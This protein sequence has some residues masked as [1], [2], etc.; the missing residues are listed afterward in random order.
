MPATQNLKQDPQ[1]W[2]EH[3]AQWLDTGLSQAAYCRQHELC[4]NGFS[5]YKRKYSTGLVP[6][7]HK[8]AGFVSVQILPEPQ[9]HDPLSLHF[10]NGVRLI[11]ITAS[12]VSVVKQLAEML[13]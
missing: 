2:R 7:K 5:Y 9:H 4:P 10:T 1:L 6:V 3:V 11:G 13:S 8:P 12:N